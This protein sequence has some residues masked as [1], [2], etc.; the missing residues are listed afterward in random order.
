MNVFAG[1]VSGP[2][3]ALISLLAIA[4]PASAV[5]QDDVTAATRA[6]LK[7]ALQLTHVHVFYVNVIGTWGFTSWTVGPGGGDTIMEQRNGT[8]H[9]L[10]QGHGA[11][12]ASL[13]AEGFRVPQDIAAALTAGACPPVRRQTRGQP[14]KRLIM[15]IRR[16]DQHGTPI[17]TVIR[18]PR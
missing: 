9:V 1:R 4:R 12:T 7:A 2:A 16:L 17:D 6:A 10:G 11:M 8:W 14:T 13:L 3:F 18:C 15:S 5:V